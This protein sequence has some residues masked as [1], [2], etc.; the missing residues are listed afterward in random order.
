MRT[1]LFYLALT[2]ASTVLAAPVSTELTKDNSI[3]LILG[4]PF[5]GEPYTKLISATNFDEVP[6]ETETSFKSAE[7]RLGK[8]IKDKIISCELITDVR[9]WK[10]IGG[11]DGE[12]VHEFLAEND[13]KPW[14]FQSANI[15]KIRCKPRLP[16]LV[17]SKV[18]ADAPPSVVA[19]LINPAGKIAREFK[20]GDK[21]AKFVVES[22]ED[23]MRAEFEIQGIFGCQ[24]QDAAG[25]QIVAAMNKAQN[26]VSKMTLE[27]AAG[28]RVHQIVCDPSFTKLEVDW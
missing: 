4:D 23:L 14:K 20:S 10:V 6:L 24:V 26:M 13:A 15:A 27:I 3:T 18:P 7:V 16:M 12:W 19:R 17:Q 25:G 21:K 2:A 1:S 8:D 28:K 5:R 9:D 11:R 22:E